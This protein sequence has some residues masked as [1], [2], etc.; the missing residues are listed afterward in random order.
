M[1]HI[2]RIL[3]LLVV[4]FI[5]FYA[6]ARAK[7]DA[8][9][10]TCGQEIAADSEVP[11]K[12]SKLMSHVAINMVVHANW[13][14]ADGGGK[15]EH[16]SLL[17]VAHEYSAIAEAAGRAASAMR[18]MKEIPATPH[19]PAR[20]DHAGQARWMRAKIEMQVEFAQMLMK[21]AEM[22]KR[23]LAE[24]EGRRTSQ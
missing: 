9:E 18:A 21:H 5:S 15:R 7:M 23:V 3:L 22:S 4:L 19:D 11:E 10:M 6:Q 17:A 14:G 24:M 12:L 1:R 20:L 13:L 16:D 2:R 8:Q